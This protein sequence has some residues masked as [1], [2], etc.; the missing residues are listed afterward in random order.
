MYL[1][2]ND[3]NFLLVKAI[4][5]S[6]IFSYIQ[7]MSTRNYFIDKYY[8]A[9]KKN[10]WERG[11][12]DAWKASFATSHNRSYYTR[13]KLQQR[14]KLF[15]LFE[16]QKILSGSLQSL[17]ASKET[18]L[19]LKAKS[20]VSLSCNTFSHSLSL[21]CSTTNASADTRQRG[22]ELIIDNKT[23]TLTNSASADQI[24]G[25]HNTTRLPQDS[26]VILS[27]PCSSQTPNNSGTSVISSVQNFSINT[28]TSS[29]SPHTNKEIR[30][31]L[32]LVSRKTDTKKGNSNAD[33]H[34]LS[35]YLSDQNKRM[36]KSLEPL[37]TSAMW[38]KSTEEVVLNKGEKGLGFSILDYQVRFT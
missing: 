29:T 16:F 37:N 26:K 14:K 18:D 12:R 28:G 34:I 10:A 15:S 30:T 17:L 36:S 8:C 25:H 7:I 22:D 4:S 19:L 13:L 27:M 20:E 11:V 21:S 6:A 33:T 2:C 23:I 35:G 24:A 32:D 31:P 3:N 38:E 9:I 5:S 1:Y